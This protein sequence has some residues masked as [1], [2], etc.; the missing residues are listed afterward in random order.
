[1][2]D[3]QP[4]V[5]RRA[6]ESGDLTAKYAVKIV[7]TDAP[8]RIAEL[9]VELAALRAVKGVPH[10]PQFVAYDDVSMGDHALLAIR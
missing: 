10:A 7:K 8:E 1:M 3:I 2:P 6:R 5:G 4:C 9:Q